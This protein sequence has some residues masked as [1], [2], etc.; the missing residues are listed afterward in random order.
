MGE[1]GKVRG[2]SPAGEEVVLGLR[3]NWRQFALLVAVNVFVGGMVGL[4]R[5]IL[6]VLAVQEFG[7]T[8][9]TAAVSFIVSFGLAKAVSNLLAGNLSQRFSRRR[10]LIAGWLFG[11]PVPF[12]LI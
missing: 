3:A 10:V 7:I 2:A 11:L 9:A 4:E 1:G 12:I 8:S 5:S 6:P